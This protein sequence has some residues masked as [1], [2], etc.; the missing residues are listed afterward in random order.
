MRIYDTYREVWLISLNVYVQ[1]LC[2]LGCD[3]VSLHELLL[4]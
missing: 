2:L 4:I 1:D 3:I